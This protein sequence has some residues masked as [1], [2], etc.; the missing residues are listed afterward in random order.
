MLGN[1]DIV[2]LRCFCC[3]AHI[4]ADLM[5]NN[6]VKCGINMSGDKAD[7][8]QMSFMLFLGG[9]S[10]VGPPSGYRTTSIILSG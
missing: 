7:G 9:Y 3:A 6:I 4:R 1:D 5:R 8:R 2:F 10:A